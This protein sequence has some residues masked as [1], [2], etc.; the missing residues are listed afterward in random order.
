M[1]ARESGHHSSR[2][3][4][5]YLRVHAVNGLDASRRQIRRCHCWLLTMMECEEGVTIVRRRKWRDQG[6]MLIS[7]LAPLSRASARAASC[8]LDATLTGGP[9]ACI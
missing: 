2:E 1:S 9:G 5:T 7:D 8:L 6:E 3:N 4:Q